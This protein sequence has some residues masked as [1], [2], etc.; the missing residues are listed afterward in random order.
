M[1]LGYKNRNAAAL[2]N[3][4][5]E[6]TCITLI[7]THA[8]AWPTYS[9]GETVTA[10]V[11][12]RDEA[13]CRTSSH[14]VGAVYVCIWNVSIGII[15]TVRLLCHVNDVMYSILAA[16]T[17]VVGQNCSEEDIDRCND[18]IS[19]FLTRVEF[20]VITPNASREEMSLHCR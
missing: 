2:P 15:T 19:P 12:C 9:V 1:L 4:R 5:Y 20:S 13:L 11:H 10:D 8:Q 17:A 14:L 16:V 6:T 18:L 3:Y 7:H